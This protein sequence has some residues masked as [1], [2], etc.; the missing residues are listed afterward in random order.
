MDSDWNLYR[1]FDTLSQE[2]RQ[3]SKTMQAVNAIKERIEERQILDRRIGRFLFMIVGI[4]FEYS[5]YMHYDIKSI[6]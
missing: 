3:V 6:K 4:K 5:S 1:P 2:P